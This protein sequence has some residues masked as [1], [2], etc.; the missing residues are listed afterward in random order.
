MKPIVVVVDGII[1]S[2]KTT[3]IEMVSSILRDHG[4]KVT[5]VREPVDKW[6]N[7]G[8]LQRFYENPTRWGYHFQTKAF[9][10]RV[11][12]NLDMYR[13][14]GNQSD[15]FILERSP[16][17]DTLFME[18]LHESSKIDDLE[19]ADYRDWW[20]LWMEIMPYQPDLFIYLCPSVDTCM[21][22]LK[23][24]NRE[25]E[26]GIDRQYQVL[27]QRKHDLFF[28]SEIVRLSDQV[29]VPCV[30]INT[31]HN[32]IEDPQLRKQ[33]AS[34]FETIIKKIRQ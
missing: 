26:Q 7:S 24:R 20:S 2:G 25:G 15:L 23:K 32:F 1:A 13:K 33:M 19:M 6:K 29:E 17:T 14:Y 4:W 3:Y 34:D 16:Y 8:I 11:R 12:E 21:L 9:H 31:D 10:D 5:V 27:L 30:K 22:R 18:L 28:G